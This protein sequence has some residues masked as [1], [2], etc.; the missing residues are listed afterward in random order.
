MGGNREVAVPGGS[1]LEPR[2]VVLALCARP[3]NGD[4]A[5]LVVERGLLARVLQSLDGVS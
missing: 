1:T 3:R 5:A 2:S 4:L